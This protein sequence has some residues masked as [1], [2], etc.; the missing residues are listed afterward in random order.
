MRLLIKTV[1]QAFCLTSFS[2]LSGYSIY[3]AR[4]R[5]MAG[6]LEFNSGFSSTEHHYF[7]ETSFASV[8]DVLF[9][10]NNN[11]TFATW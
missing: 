3:S 6:I 7:I 5:P 10:T 1:I 2:G 4:E 11:S 8:P 9:V